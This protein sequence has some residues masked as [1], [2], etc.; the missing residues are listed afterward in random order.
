MAL[1][2]ALAVKLLILWWVDVLPYIILPLLRTP[3][4]F[5]IYLR[6]LVMYEESLGEESDYRDI[7]SFREASTVFYCPDLTE[8]RAWFIIFVMGL[9]HGVECVGLLD[10]IVEEVRR[11]LQ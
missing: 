6:T 10:S 5:Y 11:P 1:I 3:A 9:V 8:N 4:S 7:A 2:S